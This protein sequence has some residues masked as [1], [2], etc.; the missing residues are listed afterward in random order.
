MTQEIIEESNEEVAEETNGEDEHDD[1]KAVD[2]NE[3]VATEVNDVGVV[4]ACLFVT[5]VQMNTLALVA[6]IMMSS[7]CIEVK[8][9]S[10]RS[11]RSF[12][13]N[14]GFCHLNRLLVQPIDAE[15]IYQSIINA[16]HIDV[17]E[18]MVF[19]PNE[20]VPLLSVSNQKGERAYLLHSQQRRVGV[21]LW[22][23]EYV[24]DSSPP[25]FLELQ[26]LRNSNAKYFYRIDPRHLR[27]LCA[28][29][30]QIDLGATGYRGAFIK[31]QHM[32]QDLISKRKLIFDDLVASIFYDK[33][34][35]KVL[36]RSIEAVKL[37]EFAMVTF[38]PRT[39][40]RAP[41]EEKQ[42]EV[43]IRSL[44]MR[45]LQG[46][47]DGSEQVD[48]SL[49]MNKMLESL[50][51]RPAGSMEVVHRSMTPTSAPL[52]VHESEC[53]IVPKSAELLEQPWAEMQ[54]GS[55]SF[56]ITC[57]ALR[58]KSPRSAN[59]INAIT[60]I[61]NASALCT[62]LT[63]CSVADLKCLA[64]CCQLREFRARGV[65]AEKE[66]FISSCYLIL[67]GSCS[68]MVQ[69]DNANTSKLFLPGQV[70]GLDVLQS[71]RQWLFSVVVDALQIDHR[72]ESRSTAL[73]VCSIPVEA[74]LRYVGREGQEPK[75]Y[76][77]AFWQYARLAGEANKESAAIEPLFYKSPPI[78]GSIGS[79]SNAGARSAILNR[80]DSHQYLNIMNSAKVRM[81]Q[82]G[83]DIYCQGEER[84]HFIFIVQGECAYLRTLAHP[85]DTELDTGV[86]LYAGDFSL[87][88]G[89]SKEWIYTRKKT[90]LE[91][92]NCNEYMAQGRRHWVW[93]QH[94]NTLH[95][96]TL[97]EAVLIPIHELAQSFP[98]FSSLMSIND[99]K[100]KA[101]AKSDHDLMV[102]LKAEELRR[103][104][105][106]DLVAKQMDHMSSSKVALTGFE[107]KWDMH[108]VVPAPSAP[109]AARP[110]KATASPRKM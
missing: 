63:C 72:E 74:L 93:E 64:S 91:L 108:P 56:H 107:T 4:E 13:V 7:T 6:T 20:V 40:R 95:A 16:I 31:S 61:L 69:E 99:V 37:H 59:Q 57:A 81:Y 53:E 18:Q 22:S 26:I 79:L 12:S 80:E 103:A 11:G 104:L 28:K 83:N 17:E 92:L 43:E 44:V 106:S 49:N 58:T 39:L 94:Q 15:L 109:A 5:T 1:E 27:E 110:S 54:A 90:G 23:I 66:E 70:L 88:D 19:K 97:V 30:S 2:D 87:L 60:D 101:L 100:Y 98:I 75:Q 65:I 38:S 89:E 35:D 96:T 47:E 33:D 50:P 62:H 32:K 3:D 105:S 21:E 46:Q 77:S 85:A 76:I 68:A 86:R 67:K 8:L 41:L 45:A 52:E 51:P 24:E 36:I 25:Y 34:T 82:P 42:N 102:S 55:P 78:R 48:S 84:F 71:Q 29:C 10:I 73:Y 14:C 9:I